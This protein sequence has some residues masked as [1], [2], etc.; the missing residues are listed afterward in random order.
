MHLHLSYGSAT[1]NQTI[2]TAVTY[3]WKDYVKGP[4]KYWKNQMRGVDM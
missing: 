4:S 3:K 2:L 1:G